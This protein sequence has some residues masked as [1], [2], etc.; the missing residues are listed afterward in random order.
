MR[1]DASGALRWS[2]AAFSGESHDD[3]LFVADDQAG[4]GYFRN[5]GKTRRQGI[6]LN[7]DARVA[8]WTF[9][10][11]Y[12]YLDATYRSAETVNGEGNSSN[13]GAAPGFEGE[14]DIEPGNRLPLVPHHVLKASAQWQV[15]P[16]AAAGRRRVIHRQF[17]RARQRERRARARRHLLSR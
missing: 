10:L 16:A 17:D 5:F 4:F 14:I 2:V 7:A 15:L 9:G 13:E 3:I 1:G 12:T 8:A 6:E 11:H